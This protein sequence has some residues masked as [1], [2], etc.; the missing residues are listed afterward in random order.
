MHRGL[1]LALALAACTD[2]APPDELD[3]IIDAHWMDVGAR[4]VTLAV[5]R[6]GTTHVYARGVANVQDRRDMRPGD[7]L[8]VGSITKT[9][10]AATILQLVDEGALSL[11]DTIDRWVPMFSLGTGVTIERALGHLT[12]L[13][14][15]TDD[16]G[17][18][19]EV[20]VR[21][22]P[23]DVV[24]F[25][26]QHPSEFAP[27][28]SFGYSNTNFV[29][30]GMVIEAVTGSSYASV[31][32][33]RLLDPLAL[34]DT[35]IEDGEPAPGLVQGYILNAVPPPFDASWG[36]GTGSFVSTAE[37]LCRWAEALYRGTVVPPDMLAFM[38]RESQPPSGINTNYGAA[39]YLRRKG[40]RD[41]VGHT[42]STMGFNAE[43]FIE[44]ASGDCVAVLSN[45][46]FGET[47][48]LAE[49]LWA[50]IAE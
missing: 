24:A 31:V 1:V 30:L 28:E 7:R 40:G 3:P 20:A 4:G 45:D 9:F 19:N 42:G 18:L 29:L 35:F 22:A 43:L 37:D 39:T 5:H 27:G 2:E 49:P 36:F 34:D 48:V 17:F 47:E 33:A 21:V 46:F 50:E 10:T 11:D 14:N 38:T 25:A 32:R 23:A 12:G 26:L 15:Y 6:D 44:P 41:V 8:R 16:A 13:Y